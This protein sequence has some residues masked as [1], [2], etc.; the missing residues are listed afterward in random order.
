MF[1]ELIS[2]SG[3]TTSTASTSIVHERQGHLLTI[4]YNKNTSSS[5]KTFEHDAGHNHGIHACGYAHKDSLV[6]CIILAATPPK[7]YTSHKIINTPWIFDSEKTKIIPLSRLCNPAHTLVHTIIDQSCF[8]VRALV[9]AFFITLTC[10]LQHDKVSKN[11]LMLWDLHLKCVQYVHSYSHLDWIQ[12]CCCQSLCGIICLCQW[13]QSM[14]ISTCSVL[15][16]QQTWN[17][18]ILSIGSCLWHFARTNYEKYSF[19]T[20][21]LL[22]N[23]EI[24]TTT[25]GITTS[26]STG[27]TAI[28]HNIHSQVIVMKLCCIKYCPHDSN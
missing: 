24:T 9:H 26:T 13:N 3:I 11:V 7:F 16:L 8:V 27:S 19:L 15:V 10:L 18:P 22:L 6:T 25:S 20:L 14:T 4:L 21:I 12:N 17:V 2:T 5:K 1:N 23:A 28:V